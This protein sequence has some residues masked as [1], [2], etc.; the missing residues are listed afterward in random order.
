MVHAIAINPIHV[1]PMPVE[2]R[3]VEKNNN[4]VNP[5]PKLPPAP[6]SPEIRPNDLR[7]TK[8]MIPYVA[9]HAA[10]APIEK[11]IIE[12]MAIGSDSA[13]PNQI[14]KAPPVVWTIHR[15]HNL[16]LI[17]NFRAAKS[18]AYPPNGRAT[19][20]AIPNVAAIIPAVCSFKL[21]LSTY[22]KTIRSLIR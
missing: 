14:Q 10:W 11:R 3:V 7:D 22:V 9:P 6:V 12:V 16:P 13:R 18:D 15:T 1:S 5:P 2:N 8:G 20:F 17:P 21:N 19:K 4:C